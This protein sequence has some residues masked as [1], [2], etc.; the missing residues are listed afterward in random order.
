MATELEK[1]P[2]Q[3]NTTGREVTIAINSFNVT[4]IPDKTVYQYDVQIGSGVEKRG[5]IKRV[6][7]SK[8][9]ADKLGPGWIF[10]GNKIAWC[11]R[12]MKG[13]L[14]T[15]IDLDQDEGL[16]PR[17]G[18]PNKH[19]VCV[20]KT[21]TVNLAA[22]RAYLTGKMSF[23]TP[24]LEAI[25]FL[26]H[27]LRQTPSMKYTS[28]KRSFFARGQERY[29]LGG[30]IEAFKGVYQSIRTCQG[31]RLAVNVDVANGTFWTESVVHQT[32]KELVHAADYTELV[33]KLKQVKVHPA[34]PDSPMQDSPAF[35]ELRRLK[36]VGI[37]AKHRGSEEKDKVFIIDHFLREDAKSFKFPV[38]DKKTGEITQDVSIYDYFRRRYNI[39]LQYW[40]LPLI[41]TTKKNVV[42][43][44]ECV[45]IAENQRYPFKTDEDQTAKMIRFAVTR[46]ND[47]I[48][49]I[50]HGLGMLKWPEDVY[51]RNYGMT[52]DTKM[53][54]TR[55]RVLKNAVIQFG[56]NTHDPGVSGRWD[57]K[58][59]KFIKPN[60]E[61]LV[62]WGVAFFNNAR[63]KVDKATVENFVREFVKI[64]IGHGGNIATLKPLIMAAPNNPAEAVQQLWQATGNKFNR[65]PQILLFMVS[66]R[67]SFHYLRIK[68]S[69]DCRY[70]VASQVMQNAQVQKA[71]P[72][73]ISNV[74]MKINAKLGGATARV[75]SKQGGAFPV[76]TMIIGADVSHASPG[77]EQP[78][79]AAMT[80]SADE[81]ATRYWAGCDTN[82]PR[83]ELITGG[84]IN[85]IL[86]PIITEWMTTVGKGRLPEHVYYFRDGVSEGQYLQV[87]QQEVQDLRNLFKRLVEGG[88]Q[89][90]FVVVVASKRHHVRFFPKFGDR[91][92]SDRNG[93]PVP[94]TLVEKDVTHPYEYD[95]YLNSHSA[96]QGTARPVHYHVLL[97]EAKLQPNYFQ[98]LIYEHCYQYIRSTTP[99]SLFPAVYY[100]HLASNR[101]RSHENVP[102]SSGPQSGPG[103]KPP[104]KVAALAAKAK[105][106]SEK[107]PTGG[108]PLMPINN[109]G[110]LAWDM[111]YV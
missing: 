102:A 89:P 42:F 79:M 94:G 85:G 48:A 26:D 15:E 19:R 6:W 106:E 101:A 53:V 92:A 14:N 55:A 31:G 80:V 63:I 95:F 30:G 5:L 96:I 44:M 37:Y 99:V 61:P 74:C 36:K 27:L 64:Y 13:E 8:S 2:A 71:N 111:W 109:I 76:P 21:N 41:Q 81:F 35:K 25:N 75:S 29:Y 88:K 28:I 17:A 67:N 103:S 107:P 105:S 104:H 9:M 18:K 110:R 52:I 72:Q 38:R 82:G 56:S 10:D 78:S 100:A 65:R 98:N 23:D 47:R 57:L 16:K 24:V 43:P 58:G 45:V 4:Q 91:V 49:A 90:K 87:L 12:D 93:N 11:L 97:D 84:N 73:Y 108:L 60:K 34:D 22:I 39:T 54:Q 62:S 3:G 20:R 66:D 1:R 7:N 77:S 40:N 69:C 46:P 50:N 83:V 33:W 59:K 51:L 32:A 86:Q 70:G 68:K